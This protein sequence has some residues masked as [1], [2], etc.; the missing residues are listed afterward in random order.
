ML[1]KK[2]VN[3]TI[4]PHATR[5][6]IMFFPNAPVPIRMLK[7]KDHSFMTDREEYQITG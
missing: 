5:L 6:E 2:K 7:K 1:G 4:R 3:V